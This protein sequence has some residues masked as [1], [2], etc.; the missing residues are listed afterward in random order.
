MTGPGNSSS[1]PINDFLKGDGTII[2]VRSPKEF[3]KGHIPGAKNIPLF[4]DK[5]REIVGTAYKKDG[6]MKALLIGL[7]FTQNKIELLKSAL[8]TFS[9][10][11]RNKK[12][13]AIKIYCWRGGMRSS[14]IA[15]LA[16]NLGLET[17]TLT[18]GYKQYRNWVLQQ[19][20][21]KL[22][23]K[24]LGG[25][26][27]VGK[28]DLLLALKQKGFYVVDLEGLAN[29]RGSS[30]GGLGL[31]SQPSTEQFENLLANSLNKAR[32]YNQ[33]IFL[34]AESANLGKCRLPNGLLSQ[35]K[36]API[37]ELTRTRKERVDQLTSIY[38]KN[39]KED[40]YEA[41]LRI[42]KRLGPNRTT[43][44]INAI[45]ESNWEKAC[46]A[47]LDYYDKC[48]DYEL[49]KRSRRKTIDISGFSIEEAVEEII[50]R[51]LLEDAI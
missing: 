14:S 5:E 45:R 44:A 17:I 32:F 25:R 47:I 27:G 31:N 40:L 41:T 2:D 7:E 35:M 23:L 3:I 38:S 15:W 16:N 24:L 48:Y 18:G 21:K 10:N 11:N 50:C 39:T 36:N 22:P 42:Q 37:F 12:I 34:E 28:T 43:E 4:S 51:N 13:A 49:E 29:H 9:K 19:F 33:S 26:T 46:I 6:Q 20:N 1:L 30:F 8:T